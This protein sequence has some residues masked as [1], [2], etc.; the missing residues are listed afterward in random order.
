MGK[1]PRTLSKTKKAMK[2]YDTERRKI[3]EINVTI[4]PAFCLKEVSTTYYSQEETKQILKLCS[5][6]KRRLHFREKRK[7]WLNVA[8]HNHGK[9]FIETFRLRA[10]FE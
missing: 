4:N 6:K 3:S 5:G 7:K 9:N 8:G 1:I 2:D 10:L